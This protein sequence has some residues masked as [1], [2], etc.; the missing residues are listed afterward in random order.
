M[1]TAVQTVQVKRRPIRRRKIRR[2][3]EPEE[4][5]TVAEA[6]ARR[7]RKINPAQYYRDNLSQ[8]G[9]G[10]LEHAMLQ[11]VKEL[12]DNGLDAA[13]L[14]KVPPYVRIDIE[15]E[16]RNYEVTSKDGEVRTYPI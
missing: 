10:D 5:A 15:A 7:M 4:P 6:E 2:R 1:G 8:L 3:K 12:V 16:K 11:T 13:E 14:M 9:F